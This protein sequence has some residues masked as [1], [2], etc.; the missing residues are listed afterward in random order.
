MDIF[1]QLGTAIII[2]ALFGFLARLLR[3]PFILAYILTGI[4][5]GPILGIISD[6]KIIATFATLGITFLLFTIG[7]EFDIL[8]LRGLSLFAF[9]AAFGQIV[10]TAAF[11]YLIASLFGFSSLASLYFGLA[12]TF[13]STALVIKLLSENK[14]LGS[15]HGKIALGIL[16]LQD[17]VAVLFL[18]IFRGVTDHLAISFIPLEIFKILLVGAL[19]SLLAFFVGRHLVPLFFKIKNVS[20]EL[21]FLIALAWCL[22]LALA[23]TKVGFP[24][25]IGAFLAGLSLASTA[26]GAEIALRIRPLR[27]FFLLIFF[28]SLGIQVMPAELFGNLPMTLVFSLFVLIGNPLIVLLIMSFL[29]FRKR[30][31]FLAALSSSQVS[32]FSLILIASGINLGHLDPLAL[33]VV[34]SVA[35][36]TLT[37]SSYLIIYDNKIFALIGRYL[38]IFERKKMLLKEILAVKRPLENHVILFGCD[39]MG[40]SILR[41]LLKLHKNILVVDFNPELVKKLLKE[42]IQAICGDIEDPEMME[43]INLQ[44]AK[45]V[46]STVPD[47]E[48]NLMLLFHLRENKK[49]ITYV[50]SENIEE[51]KELYRAGADYVILPHKL[52]GEYV[53]MLLEKFGTEKSKIKRQKETRAL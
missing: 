45:M 2:A 34:S 11:G 5:L 27:D 40:T 48:A 31:S 24:L 37:L 36:V 9:L 49:L 23:S 35:I 44:K 4:I 17:V 52:S 16:L 26:T 33:S 10:F 38:N 14:E 22:A 50:T 46:I 32:E 18:L 30:T 43:K 3:Q 41:E 21:M 6:E 19:F 53:A 29:G 42:K 28:I 12:L 15:L 20:A 25:E 7:L 1:S 47:L 39:R 51:A 13:S 8:A